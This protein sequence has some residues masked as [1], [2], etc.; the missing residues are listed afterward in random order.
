M[1]NQEEVTGLLLSP[2][3]FTTASTGQIEAAF[4]QVL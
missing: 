4:H 1:A 2:R 3:G